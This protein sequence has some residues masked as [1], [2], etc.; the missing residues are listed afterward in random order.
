M[1]A[2][3]PMLT[4]ENIV[5][6]FETPDGVLTAVDDVSFAVRAGRVPVGHRAVRLRQVHAVQHHRRADGRV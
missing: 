2:A 5:K 3:D 4:V 6:Q 1:A